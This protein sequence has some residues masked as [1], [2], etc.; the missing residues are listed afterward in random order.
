MALKASESCIG[1]STV[2]YLGH[3]V[4]SGKIAPIDA[5]IEA[6]MKISPPTTQKDLRSFLGVTRFCRH[7][8]LTLAD[9]AASLTNLLCGSGKGAVEFGWDSGCHSTN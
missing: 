6:L 8:I 2:K 1:R 7:F 9:I 5:K 4:G 3:K